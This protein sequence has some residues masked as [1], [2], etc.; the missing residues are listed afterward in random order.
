MTPYEVTRSEQEG[1]ATVVLRDGAADLEAAFAPEA[2]MVACSLRH[3]GDELLG[4]RKGLA[5]YARTGSTMGIP[6]LHPWANRIATLACEVGGRRVRL[7]PDSPRIR[8]DEHGLP[9]HGLL[10]GHPGWEVR[11]SAAD[12]ESAR[13]AAELDFGA[14]PEL[15]GPFPFPHRVG[16]EAR[17][18]DSALTVTTT[19]TA[20]GADPVPISFG[21]HPYLQLPGLP[22]SEW[23]VRLPVR[24]RLVLDDRG[25]PT[26][27]TEDVEPYRGR[28]GDRTWDDGFDRLED[29]VEFG[30]SGGGREVTVAFGDGY[31]VAQVFAPPGQE[32]IC[33][34]PMTAP[35]NALVTGEGLGLAAPERPF[36]ATF[37]ISVR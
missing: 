21:W 27:G 20:T 35:T 33:F 2:G 23:Q 18:A 14:D 10:G 15:V 12:A 3:R 29:P 31:P 19:V 25:L 1:F 11:A 34:E 5:A 36:R 16:V 13:L 9:I 28:V 30:L 4:Q 8:L 6:L 17:L 24:R 26:G 37:S 7:D 32:L 22:R